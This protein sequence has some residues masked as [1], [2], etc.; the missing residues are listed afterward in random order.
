[1]STLGRYWYL[2]CST[3]PIR[4]IRTLRWRVKLTKIGS[5]GVRCSFG[6]I[7]LLVRGIL[8]PSVGTDAL[9][10]KVLYLPCP[11]FSFL[12]TGLSYDL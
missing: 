11:V 5:G 2:W 3:S 8:Y 7:K 6:P 9:R 12:G 4:V 1:M 10:I